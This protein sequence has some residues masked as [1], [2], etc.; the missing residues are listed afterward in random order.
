MCLGNSADVENLFPVYASG[1]ATQ[2]GAEH[3][4]LVR[5]DEAHPFAG[6]R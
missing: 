5:V 1:R 6:R 4:V 2:R 3:V